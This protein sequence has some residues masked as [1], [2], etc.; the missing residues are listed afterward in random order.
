MTPANFWPRKRIFRAIF[1]YYV[2]ALLLCVAI[3]QS[4]C[5][6]VPPFLTTESPPHK[7]QAHLHR[8]TCNINLNLN[9]DKFRCKD[10]A[11]SSFCKKNEIKS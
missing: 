11:L 8:Q 2:P 1:A 6:S 9:Y 5:H 4:Y 7:K 10:S 3:L